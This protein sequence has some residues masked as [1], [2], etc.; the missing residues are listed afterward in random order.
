MLA[1][2]PAIAERAAI[3]PLSCHPFHMQAA[4]ASQRPPRHKKHE[5]KSCK[6]SI[7]PSPHLYMHVAITLRQV[8]EEVPP[9]SPHSYCFGR[10]RKLTGGTIDSA[11]DFPQIPMQDLRSCAAPLR[12]ASDNT[13]GRSQ[14]FR[15]S[16]FL[17]QKLRVLTC[18]GTTTGDVAVAAEDKGLFLRN[19]FQVLQL[20]GRGRKTLKAREARDGYPNLCMAGFLKTTSVPH[21]F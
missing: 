15:L 18:P 21:S 7:A 4:S 20:Q 9:P 1:C 5:D 8:A 2:P 12:A 11:S 10:A 17:A 3:G 14:P 6:E 13:P 19:A 16:A